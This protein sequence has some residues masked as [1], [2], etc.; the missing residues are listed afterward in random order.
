MKS[1]ISRKKLGKRGPKMTQGP[2]KQGSWDS[3]VAG[4]PASSLCVHVCAC[5]YVWVSMLSASVT[6]LNV[7]L[8]NG[9]C[10]H[11]CVYRP[12]YVLQGPPS[13]PLVSAESPGG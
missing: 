5:M 10:M 4:Y 11:L 9:V 6:V 2:P 7:C 13:A 3:S 1:L 8:C 12:V